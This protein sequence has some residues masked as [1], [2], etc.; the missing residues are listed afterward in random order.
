M[1]S[2]L[3]LKQVKPNYDQ[4]VRQKARADKLMNELQ[5]NRL[6]DMQ[7]VSLKLSNTS[8]LHRG[9]NNNSMRK[10]EKS[11]KISGLAT[12]VHAMQPAHNKRMLIP[13]LR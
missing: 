13:V 10:L 9:E 7:D 12:T 3:L 4:L 6:G 11:S 8:R 2:D 1:K 5:Y